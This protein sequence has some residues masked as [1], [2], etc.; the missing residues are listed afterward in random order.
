MAF[1]RY[2]FLGL[3]AI[4]L[5][6]LSLANRSEVTLRLLPQDLGL[7]F[8]ADWVITL[9]LFVVIFLSVGLGLMVGFTWEWLREHKH[10]AEANA[11]R[12]AKEKLEKKLAKSEAA[13]PQDDVLAIL[14]TAR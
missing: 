8:D 5:L 7:Q 6:V 1:I 3:V 10:R 12:A 4:V 11:Q 2:I 13:A 14:E 9:P